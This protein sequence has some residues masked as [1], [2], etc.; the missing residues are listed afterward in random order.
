MYRECFWNKNEAAIS[1]SDIWIAVY[2]WICIPKRYSQDTW[3][4]SAKATTS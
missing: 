3:K 2:F 4:N 1:K